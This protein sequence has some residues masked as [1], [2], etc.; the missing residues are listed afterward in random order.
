[1]ASHIIKDVLKLASGNLGAQLISIAVLPLLTRIYEPEAF[2][3]TATFLWTTGILG[4]FATMSYHLAIPV[5]TSQRESKDLF[6]LGCI[7]VGCISLSTFLIVGVFTVDLTE[8]LNLSGYSVILYLLPFYVLLDGYGLLMNYMQTRKRCYTNIGLAT[9][10]RSATGATGRLSLGQFSNGA[11]LSIVVADLCALFV[12]CVSL[13][14]ASIKGFKSNLA[15]YCSENTLR[16]TWR[17]YWRYP[18]FM[19]GS[20]LFN[21]LAWM[22]PAILL[23]VQFGPAVAGF[24]SL[25]FRLIQLPMSFV[26][27]AIAQV[28]YQN[29]ADFTTFGDK[30]GLRELIAGFFSKLILISTCFSLVLAVLSP[31][32]FKLCFG[33]QWIDA[34]RYTQLLSLWALA[35]FACSPLSGLIAIL[36]LQKF[37][38]AWNFI[39]LLGRVTI[40]VLAGLYADPQA[41]ML[42]FS[43][44]AVFTYGVLVFVLFKSAGVS[45]DLVWRQLT[46][47]LTHILTYLKNLL[48]L[49][50]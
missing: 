7:S 33:E 50:S 31:W 41:A 32:A 15:A 38:I 46:S 17:K 26:G 6:I 28:F 20:N 2:G 23:A 25:G 34:G 36:N 5:A 48:C 14:L 49:K 9:A 37:G 1:M 45:V 24:Y 22:L 40:V 43:V 39:N 27:K 10:G 4:G 29:A 18:T 35:W 8:L 19:T 44:F 30:E 47:T 42:G 3:V 11:P 16:I 21:V 13:S 12:Y